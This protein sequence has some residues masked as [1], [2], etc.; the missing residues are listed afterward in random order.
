MRVI[1]YTNIILGVLATATLFCYFFA[2]YYYGIAPGYLDHVEGEL[3]LLS[4]DFLNGRPLYTPPDSLGYT[5]NTYGPNHFIAQSAMLGLVEPN[6]PSSKLIT[7]GT[8]CVAVLLFGVHIWRRHGYLLVSIAI[9]LLLAILLR[10]A[11]GSFWVRPDNLI[12]FL[13]T[14]PNEALM[15]G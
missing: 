12:L 3:T 13:V 10:Q 8:S 2:S 4:W 11:P 6:I 15:S 9:L 1:P 14:S 5:I 7:L